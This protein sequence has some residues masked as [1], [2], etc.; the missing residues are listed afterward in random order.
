MIAHYRMNNMAWLEP[1]SLDIDMLWSP[2]WVND[3]F[4]VDT[5]E[6][7]D[8][9]EGYGLMKG[10]QLNLVLYHWSHKPAPNTCY[11]WLKD[12]NTNTFNPRIRSHE[13]E[14]ATAGS[15]EHD[16]QA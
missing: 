8:F 6:E 10:K 5:E 13:R 7:Y 3:L 15:T 1:H 12:I 9:L 2:V 14:S 16:A 4:V 11:L